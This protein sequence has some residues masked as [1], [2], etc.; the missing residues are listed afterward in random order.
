MAIKQVRLQKLGSSAPSNVLS[1]SEQTRLWTGLSGLA[2]A[3]LFFVGDMLFYGHLGTGDNFAS[4]ALATVQQSSIERLFAGGLVGPI[5]ACLC[6]IGFWHVYL[7]VKAEARTLGRVMLVAFFSMMVAGSAVHTLWV[8]K[9]IAMRFC[10]A[11]DSEC[12]N[13]LIL[14]KSYWNLA[15]DMSAIPGWLGAALLAYLVIAGHTIYPRW[16]IV[17]NPAMFLFLSTSAVYLPAPFGAI[18]VGGS[19][20]L[21]IAA[22]FAVS[23]WTTRSTSIM[24][25]S[26]QSA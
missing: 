3:L 24:P 25:Q 14:T 15:Y 5:A 7:N 17:A 9:G 13:L 21:S 1:L 20:N 12:A 22:F 8:A 10:S 2:G 16:A 26:P 19:T 6:I 23:L 18:V 4:G 11:P